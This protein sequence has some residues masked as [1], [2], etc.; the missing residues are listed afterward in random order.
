MFKHLGLK[1]YTQTNIQIL[2]SEQ[3][4]GPHARDVSS[5]EVVLWM[6]VEHSQRNALEVF[7][8]E[9]APAGT[10]M[11]KHCQTQSLYFM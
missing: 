3:T 8:R 1:D 10:G 11:G 4:Y 9:I 7:S 6:A 5:R 2:G